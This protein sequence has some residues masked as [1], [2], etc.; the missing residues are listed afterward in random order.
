MKAV[1][2][3]AAFYDR[4]IEDVTESMRSFLKGNFEQDAAL[5]LSATETTRNAAAN[6][7]YGKSFKD[8]SEAEKQFTLLSMV[9]E[10][11]KASGALGQAARESDT[12]TNQLG[13][14]KQSVTDLKA[15]AGS[16]FLKPAVQVLKI[17]NGLVQRATAAIQEMTGETGFLTRSFERF[18]ALVKRLQPAIDRMSQTLSRGISKGIDVAKGIVDKLG[19][20]ENVLKIAAIAAGAFIAVMSVAKIVSMIKAVGGLAGIVSKLAKIFSLAN[21]KILAIIA[22]VVILALIIEDFINFMMGNDSVIG[23][24]FEKAGISAEDARQ[25]IVNAWNKVYT[26][27]SRGLAV[28]SNGSSSP[29]QESSKVFFF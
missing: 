6:E 17:L 1:T 21:L 12:W 29:C 2:D 22:V 7:L 27:Y 23:T 11:N 19:G 8:L 24:L 10:A 14:L 26:M 28:G 3:S 15:A 18:H 9:E 25:M 20:L 4:S 5:G 13:N 16:A